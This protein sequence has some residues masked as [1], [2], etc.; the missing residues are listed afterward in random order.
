M[1]IMVT[2]GCGY[3][4]SALIPALLDK[5]HEV[6]VLDLQWFGNTLEN[7]DNLSLAKEDIRNQKAVRHYMQGCDAVIHLAC[8]SN[9]VSLELNPALGKSINFDCFPA[10]VREAKHAGVSRFLYASSSS[11]YGIKSEAKVTEDLTL[12]P[13]TDYARYKGECE[14]I[15]MAEASDTFCVTAIRPGAVC[16]YAP[17]LRLDLVVNLLTAQAFYN[18]EITVLGGSQLRSHLNIKDMARA[19]I[20][21]LDAPPDKINGEVFNISNENM[22]VIDLAKLI[23]RKFSENI[24]IKTKPTDDLRSYHICSDKIYNAIGFKPAFTAEDAIAK[25]ISNGGLCLPMDGLNDSQ[26]HNVKRMLE[27]DIA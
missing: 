19:Y 2:G 17:R 23:A 15:L 1:R 18:K 4:G 22:S 14:P 10:L 25:L 21:L 20:E 24:S 13:M 7:H 5:G 12:E 3:V 16:G 6:I 9:D 8:I 27:L 11:V 26:Y